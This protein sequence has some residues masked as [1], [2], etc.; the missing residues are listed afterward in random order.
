VLKEGKDEDQKICYYLPCYVRFKVKEIGEVNIEGLK[1]AVSGT[2]LFSFYYGDMPKKLVKQF[3][4][5]NTEK[6]ILLQFSRQ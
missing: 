2:L 6:S 4:G 5:K 1:G 3:V